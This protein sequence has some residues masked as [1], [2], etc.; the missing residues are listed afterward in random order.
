VIS[1]AWRKIAG[2]AEE[3]ELREMLA[4]AAAEDA[5]AGFP[6]VSLD[7]PYRDDAAHLVVRLLPDGR[8]G[9]DASAPVAA[10]LRV[11]PDPD[12]GTATVRY[13]VR[14]RFRSRGISTLLVETIGLD[15]RAEGGWAGTGVSAL[16]IWARGDHPA[17]QRMARRFERFGVHPGRREWQLLAP[18]RR[19][20]RPGRPGRQGIRAR[21]PAHAAEQAAAAALWHGRADREELP[22]QASVLIAGPDVPG[23]LWYDPDADERTEYGTAGR[24]VAVLAEPGREEIR[25]ELVAAAMTGL[26]DRGLRVAAITVDAD[27]HALTRSCRLLGFRHDR[28]DVEYIV[29]DAAAAAPAGAA[30]AHAA[31]EAGR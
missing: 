2:P 9:H 27:D 25:A 24:I 6:A 31:A 5:E 4:E 1:Y 8:P 21:P 26:R 18:L 29:G 15:L 19:S 3:R 10:Y 7:Q 30:L 23:A 22:R 11:E 16:R 14:P 20:G 17:A 12:G 13:V 28:T